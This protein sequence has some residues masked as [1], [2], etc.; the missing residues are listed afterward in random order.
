VRDQDEALHELL[1]RVR[2]RFKVVSSMMGILQDYSASTGVA[3][4][5]GEAQA[6]SSARYS[7][8]NLGQGT[9]KNVLSATGGTR[10][11]F[12]LA[13]SPPQLG[14]SG[15]RRETAQSRA[16]DLSY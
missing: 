5:Q 6:L 15:T 12:A 3:H 1:D 9:V 10:E 2:G 4:G 13:S 7:T 14:A 11:E 8:R 16:K